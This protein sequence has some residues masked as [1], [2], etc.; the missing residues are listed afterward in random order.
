MKPHIEKRLCDNCG[1]CAEICPYEVF[2]FDENG[3][4]TVVV[5]E[6][7]VECTACVE[8]CKKKAMH[9]GD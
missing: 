1:E 3:D 6:D 9:M 5:P 7:C 8:Q 4:V 2:S